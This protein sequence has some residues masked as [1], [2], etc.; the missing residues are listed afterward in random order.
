VLR[1]VAISDDDVHKQCSK[2]LMY[3]TKFCPNTSC[4]NMVLCK[5]YL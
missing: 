5:Y 4:C 1:N 2:A 3:H